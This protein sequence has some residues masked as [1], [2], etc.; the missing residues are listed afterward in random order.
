V[1]F[2]VTVTLAWFFIA[3]WEFCKAAWATVVLG[4][5]F[6]EQMDNMDDKD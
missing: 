1:V 4:K 3:A 2:S 6:R 5:S